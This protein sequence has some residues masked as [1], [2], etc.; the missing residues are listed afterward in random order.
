MVGG[1]YY[2]EASRIL[3]ILKPILEFRDYVY[4]SVIPNLP[5]LVQQVIAEMGELSN[6]LDALIFSLLA[7]LMKPLIEHLSGE[8]KD[9]AHGL[10][11]ASQVDEDEIF[12]PTSTS[13]NPTHTLLAKDHFVNLLNKPAGLVA[14]VATNL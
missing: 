2:E 13:S 5:T 7:P 14:T 12:K 1:R 4:K 6:A 10:A 11:A 9:S 8:L 3:G